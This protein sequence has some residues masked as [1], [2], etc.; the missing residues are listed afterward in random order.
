MCGG[1]G[2]N[3]HAASAPTSGANGT[4]KQ[5]LAPPSRP[6]LQT[7]GSIASHPSVSSSTSSPTSPSADGGPQRERPAASSGHGSQITKVWARPT[8]DE[9][10]R[11]VHFPPHPY[12]RRYPEAGPSSSP[13]SST[14][15]PTTTTTTTPAVQSDVDEPDR[16]FAEPEEIVRWRVANCRILWG[17]IEDLLGYAP[18]DVEETISWWAD[19]VHPDELPQLEKEIAEHCLPNFNRGEAKARLWNGVYRFKKKDGSWL[20]IGDRMNTVRDDE[21]YPVY[22]ESYM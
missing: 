16:P 15:S 22:C 6:S 2:D 19:R 13:A 9:V 11:E 21:G 10:R 12:A 4:T 20:T 8:T 17:P 5:H 3:H 7:T 14:S 1:V 18:S